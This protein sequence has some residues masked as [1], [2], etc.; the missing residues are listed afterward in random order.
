MFTRRYGEIA[1]LAIP[2]GFALGALL[3]VVIAITGNPDWRAHLT[4]GEFGRSIVTYG[5]TGVVVAVCALLGGG[6]AVAIRDR[7]FQ[8]QR[9]VRVVWAAIG[10]A[11]GV[12]LLGVVAEVVMSLG[13]TPSD[14]SGAVVV[15]FF[16]AVPAAIAAAALV[17]I[18]EN[19]AARP[20]SSQ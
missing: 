8:C 17:A 3:F 7:K 9:S 6:I 10:A 20:L 16:L 4:L 12:L 11:T 1:V 18:A 15:S 14:W 13:R 5:L 2:L 19:R